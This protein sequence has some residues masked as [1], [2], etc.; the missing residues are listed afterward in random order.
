M[1]GRLGAAQDPVFQAL[2][3]WEDKNA[4]GIAQANEL[5]TLPELDVTILDLNYDA[6]FV[7]IEIRFF[8]VD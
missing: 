3:L 7:E 6:S 2:R 4:D 1:V 8:V 5:F